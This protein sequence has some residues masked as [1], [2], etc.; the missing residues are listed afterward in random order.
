MD[1]KLSGSI[2]TDPI[3]YCESNFPETTTEFKRLKEIDYKKF[4]EKQLDY[5]PGNIA[6]GSNLQNDE[7]VLFSL[8]ALNVRINDKIQ[9]LLHLINKKHRSPKNESIEDS[10]LDTSVYGVIA[11][12]VING[13]WGK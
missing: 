1:E 10:Y 12:I 8:G 5:G 3:A 4:C 13:K 11:R 6:M 2:I 9:R 7:D